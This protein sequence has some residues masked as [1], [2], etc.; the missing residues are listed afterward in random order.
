VSSGVWDDLERAGP[1][2]VTVG[3]VEIRRGSRVRLHPR[4]L[5]D[6]HSAAL[7]GRTGVVESI[8]E[9][10]EGG[11]R[12]A[13]SPHDDP[14]R[15]LG[16]ARPGH[17]FFFTPEE[18]E[19]L[20]RVLVAGIGNIFLGDDGFG[21]EV[22]RRLA[23]GP[24]PDGV[25]VVDYGIRGFDLAYA[26]ASGYESAVLVDIAPL[27]A[28]PGSLAEL[29]PPV[30]ENDAEID[31]HAMDPVRVLRLARK[32][33][34]TPQRTIVLACQPGFVPDPDE[35]GDVHVALSAPVRAAVDEAVGM[36]RGLVEQ[37][38]SDEPKGGDGG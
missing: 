35:G 5:R 8:E 30:D 21:S 19:P 29:E 32:L 15:D 13:I 2:A 24:M 12:V 16:P 7:D 14:G 23:D 38:L 28:E 34:G 10:M 37:L 36:V 26:L 6:I 1:D 33:G 4:D 3:G 20:A 25:D 27:G 9:L 18:V 31:S 11:V 22:A 17:R